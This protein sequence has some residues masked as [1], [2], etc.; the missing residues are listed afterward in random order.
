MLEGAPTTLTTSDTT[1]FSSGPKSESRKKSSARTLRELVEA[2][3]TPFREDDD[4]APEQ[5]V[6]ESGVPGQHA[7]VVADDERDAPSCRRR[8]VP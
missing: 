7:V 3:P 2:G 4:A 5:R 6:P 8:A 1:S